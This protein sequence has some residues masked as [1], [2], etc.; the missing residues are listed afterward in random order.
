[1]MADGWKDLCEQLPRYGSLSEL[2]DALAQF[3]ILDQDERAA[4]W[5]FAWSR[6]ERDHRGGRG[7]IV[8]PGGPA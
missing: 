3:A 7:Q 2:D 5:L 1:M 4:L 8:R 6:R